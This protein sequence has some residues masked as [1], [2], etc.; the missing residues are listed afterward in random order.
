MVQD[1]L[2]HTRQLKRRSSELYIGFRGPTH[3]QLSNQHNSKIFR[4]LF[5]TEKYY[6]DNYASRIRYATLLLATN[7]KTWLGSVRNKNQS[8]LAV[9]S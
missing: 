6:T 8:E 7:G 4:F 2:R 5:T 1:C 9:G 3:Q